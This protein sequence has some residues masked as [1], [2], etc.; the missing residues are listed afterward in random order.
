ME[1]Y[2]ILCMHCKVLGNTMLEKSNLTHSALSLYFGYIVVIISFFFSL[3]FCVYIFWV[4][5]ED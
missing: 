3:L 2:R 5:I 1:K 4:Y